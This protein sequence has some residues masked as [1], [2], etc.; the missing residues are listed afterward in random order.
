MTL[1]NNNVVWAWC[2]TDSLSHYVHSPLASK[3]I[4]HR[5]DTA[6]KRCHLHGFHECISLGIISFCPCPV[7]SCPYFTCI[8]LFLKLIPT[9]A[10]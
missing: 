5:E 8:C 3:K 7:I 9:F 2:W 1:R 10:M 6:N 4:Y